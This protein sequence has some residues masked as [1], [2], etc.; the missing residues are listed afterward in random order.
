MWFLGNW[1]NDLLG[2]KPWIK[3]RKT[4]QLWEDLHVPWAKEIGDG[5]NHWGSPELG[6]AEVQLQPRFAS[7]SQCRGRLIIEIDLKLIEK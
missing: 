5:I 3:F 1:E 2:W 7:G 4:H 6:E